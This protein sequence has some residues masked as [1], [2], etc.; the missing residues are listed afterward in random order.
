M[1]RTQRTTT[2]VFLLLFTGIKASHKLFYEPFPSL[3]TQDKS[4][5]P[6]SNQLLLIEQLFSIGK[7][8]DARKEAASLIRLALEGLRYLQTYAFYSTYDDVEL[9]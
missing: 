4:G 2:F 6:G 3:S 1:S 5:D 8:T 7:W 9:H